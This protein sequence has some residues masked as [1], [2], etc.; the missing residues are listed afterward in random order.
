MTMIKGH[1]GFEEG[2]CFDIRP[3]VSDLKLLKLRNLLIE[4]ST[5][6]GFRGTLSGT[7]PFCK[8]SLFHRAALNLQ[9]FIYSR[10][11]NK[12]IKKH[13]L[14]DYDIY[15]LESG[16]DFY[17]DYRLLPI[18]KNMGKILIANY[19]GDDFRNQG[20]SPT[21]HRLADANLTCE[22]D[23]H[24]SYPGSIYEY[25]P[26]PEFDGVPVEQITSKVRIVHI[27]RTREHMP[28]KGSEA[29]I[30][31]AQKAIVG[32]NAEFV[33]LYGLSHEQV[34][35]ELL[36]SHIL[37]DQ[38]GGVGGDGYGMIAV[39]ALS[40]GLNV[41][42]EI[43]P[44]METLMPDHPFVNVQSNTLQERLEKLIDDSTYRA[45][46][47]ELGMSWVKK[48]HGVRTIV[49]RLYKLYDNLEEK[50]FKA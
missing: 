16:I 21:M 11:I 22:W 5:I 33:F 7:P 47:S 45:K 17:K 38:I 36:H 50:A 39:E 29:I 41:C 49:D 42:V 27:I 34:L 40:R 3:N 44:R 18:L 28:Y 14:L 4:N 46:Q 35:N 6:D 30:N 9:D 32:R 24:F 1:P 10:K 37:I 15:H 8:P 2:I 26:M 23:I 31:A 12:I 43:Q 13:N 48:R 25:L 19:H 20:V